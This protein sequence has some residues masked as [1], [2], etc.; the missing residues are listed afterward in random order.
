MGRFPPPSSI[1]KKTLLN[2]RSLLLTLK[3]LPANQIGV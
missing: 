3:R 2:L 1:P